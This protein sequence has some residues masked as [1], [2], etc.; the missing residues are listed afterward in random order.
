M[1]KFEFGNF[2]ILDTGFYFRL[3]LEREQHLIKGTLHNFHDIGGLFRSS[4]SGVVIVKFF[5][6][7]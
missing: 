4:G 7:F 2:K 1:Q 3:Y 6:G 5:S